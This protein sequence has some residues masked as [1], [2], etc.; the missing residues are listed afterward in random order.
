[1]GKC[2]WPESVERKGG[3]Q[4]AEGDAERWNGTLVQRRPRL[5]S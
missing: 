4:E 1:M 5:A 3:R 2:D